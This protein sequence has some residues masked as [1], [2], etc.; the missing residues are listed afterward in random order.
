MR[1]WAGGELEASWSPVRCGVKSHCG[2]SG[3]AHRRWGGGGGLY[4]FRFRSASAGEGLSTENVK[5]KQFFVRWDQIGHML[6]K[7]EDRTSEEW[8]SPTPP[9]LV[10][11]LKNKLNTTFPLICVTHA[12]T[13]LT[14]ASSFGW[15][16]VNKFPRNGVKF[17][18][19]VQRKGL[20][21]VILSN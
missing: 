17:K 3:H 4:F 12:K 14:A 18:K 2:A 5:T 21:A 16:N 6:D 19:P 15:A 20:H 8:A 9:A 7:N 11:T 10:G 13:K 1:G